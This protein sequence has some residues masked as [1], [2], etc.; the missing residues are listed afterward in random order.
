MSITKA[1]EAVQ[2][3]DFIIITDATDRENEGDLVFAA[4]FVSDEKIAFMLE[5]TSG[6][7]CVGMEQ[8][9]LDDLGLTMMVAHNTSKHG[10][11]FT[12]PVD[13]KNMFDNGVSARD[14]ALTIRTLMEGGKSDLVIPGHVFP[15]RAHSKGVLER[16]GHTEASVD[17]CRLAGVYPAGALCELMNKNG[18]MMRG[19]DLEE[20]AKRFKIPIVTIDEIEE[21]LRFKREI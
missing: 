2:K 14:R 10:T 16:A 11:P 21:Y 6:I 20:F 5:H 9:R 19:R 17:I 13:A 15:L 7:I 4:Q 3:G 8:K 1:V 12:L 18:A